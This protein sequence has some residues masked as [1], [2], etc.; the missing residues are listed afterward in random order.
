MECP[1]I[2]QSRAKEALEEVVESKR[3]F[4]EYF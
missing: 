1:F 3:E 4:V 2:M